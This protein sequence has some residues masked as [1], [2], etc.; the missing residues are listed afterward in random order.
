[1]PLQQP[2]SDAFYWTGTEVNATHAYGFSMKD[3]CLHEY[4]KTNP[5]GYVRAFLFYFPV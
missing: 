4:E 5:N 1:M 3:M 2:G